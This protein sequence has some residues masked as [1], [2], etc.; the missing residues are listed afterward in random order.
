MYRSHDKGHRGPME[1]K[2]PWLVARSALAACSCALRQNSLSLYTLSHKSHIR[3]KTSL[4]QITASLLIIVPRSEP[5]S[6]RSCR[7]CAFADR[8]RAGL[9]IEVRRLNNLHRVCADA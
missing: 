3:N 9:E 5:F 6:M 7:A 4:V 8:S 1:S 2:Q